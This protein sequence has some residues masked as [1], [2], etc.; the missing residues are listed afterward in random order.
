MAIYW[1]TEALP[2]AV[3]SLLPIILTPLVGLGSAKEVSSHYLSDTSMLFLGGLIIAVAIEHWNIHKRLALAILMYVGTETRWLMLGLMLP[4]WLLSMWISNTAT[5]AMMIPITNAILVQLKEANVPNE[6]IVT[7]VYDNDALKLEDIEVNGVIKENGQPTSTDIEKTY[8]TSNYKAEPEDNMNQTESKEHLEICKMMSICIAHAANCGGLG[9]LTGTGPNVVFKGQ[10]D[11]IFEKYGGESPVTFSSWF[12]FGLPISAIM[13]LLSWIWLQLYFLGKG[14]LQFCSGNAESRSR[15]KSLLRK[16]YASLGPI[17]TVS[18]STPAI[19]LSCSL[20]IF[21]SRLQ[22]FSEKGPIPPLL[23]WKIVEKKLPWGVVILL[24]GGFALAFVS[25]EYGLSKWLGTQLAV[26]KPLDPW[27]VNMILCIIVAAATEVT[28]NVAMCTLLMPILAELSLQLEVNPLYFMFPAAIA[29]S[30]A[31]ML[32]VATPPNAVVF[33]YGYLKVIDMVKVGFL[34]NILGI[35]VLVIG[36]ET[37]GEAV[38]GFHKQPDIFKH[39]LNNTDIV[40]N[41]C[42]CNGSLV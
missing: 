9:S 41:T 20:F 28:S 35:V 26:L 25:Q 23:T 2:I 30:F 33:A 14:C 13:L 40:N 22:K 10:S 42:I 11:I 32:P 24:G 12:A 29:T 19:L 17:E 7:E 36:T 34:M 18:N 31:F 15:I 27:I 3:T 8:K 4:T 38:F 39:G 5:T 16:E 1:I 6:E 21:P 37:W